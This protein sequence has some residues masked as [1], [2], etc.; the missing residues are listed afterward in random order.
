MYSKFEDSSLNTIEGES[1]RAIEVLKQQQKDSLPGPGSYETNIS[2]CVSTEFQRKMLAQ[3][4]S[5]I[6]IKNSLMSSPNNSFGLNSS[7]ILL[8]NN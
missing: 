1:K 3:N 5:K 2:S 6:N 7:S 8:N 4:R